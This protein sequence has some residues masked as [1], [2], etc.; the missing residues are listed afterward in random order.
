VSRARGADASESIL[1]TRV[2]RTEDPRFPTTGR[3]YTEDVLA[4][5]TGPDLAALPTQEDTGMLNQ[6]IRQQPLATD[7]VRFVGKAVAAVVT[8]EPYQDDDATELVSVDHTGACRKPCSR[9][10]TSRYSVIRLPMRVCHPL[11]PSIDRCLV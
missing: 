5:F 3:G 4:V 8:Q 10:A 6:E 7:I 9:H 2:L 1:G 11:P